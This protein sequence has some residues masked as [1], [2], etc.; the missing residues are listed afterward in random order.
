M[1]ATSFKSL[2][3][4]IIAL[5]VALATLQGCER[6]SSQSGGAEQSQN[7]KLLATKGMEDRKTIS[8]SRSA[9]TDRE[10]CNLIRTV[11]E[12]ELRKLALSNTLV[13][14]KV[15]Q[16]AAEARALE[17]L[18]IA[19]TEVSYTGLAALAGHQALNDLDIGGN[20]QIDDAA[21]DALLGI[22]NLR[23]VTVIGTGISK[24]VLSR[25]R[26]A[27]IWVLADDHHQ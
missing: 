8:C 6:D 10:V 27:G 11:P 18:E 22:P 1:Q 25:L 2:V 23:G 21:I 16:C 13:T 24:E 14:D 17:I 12:G 9:A 7:C 3:V 15:L 26:D 5:T 19:D 20:D 4:Q